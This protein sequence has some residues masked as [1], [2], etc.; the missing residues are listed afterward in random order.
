MKS[1]FLLLCFFISLIGFSQKKIYTKTFKGNPR[2]IYLT[3]STN[4]S[5]QAFVYK[6][7]SDTNK[8]IFLIRNY[9]DGD[10]KVEGNSYVVSKLALYPKDYESKVGD[11]IFTITSENVLIYYYHKSDMMFK[12][13]KIN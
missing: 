13:E 6:T 4:E 11:F 9:K 8:T 3:N 5:G 7:P 10:V 1:I 2:A 12:N